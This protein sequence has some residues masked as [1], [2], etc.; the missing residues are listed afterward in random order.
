MNLATIFGF[1]TLNNPYKQIGRVVNYKL[2]SMQA[3]RGYGY[4]WRSPWMDIKFLS[5]PW[6]LWK[7]ISK[8]NFEIYFKS[9]F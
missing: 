5:C 3:C 2:N 7:S 4:P 1:S 6:I 8:S 9:G